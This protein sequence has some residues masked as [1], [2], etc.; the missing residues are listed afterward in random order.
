[1]EY[2]ESLGWR[3]PSDCTVRATA[4]ACAVS[5]EE[6]YEA[7]RRAGRIK[8]HGFAYPDFVFGVPGPELVGAKVV[9]VM[10]R[11]KFDRK[12][13]EHGR[14]V[15]KV[16][17][18]VFAVVDGV[19]NEAIARRLARSFRYAWKFELEENDY[20]NRSSQG[21]PVACGRDPQNQATAV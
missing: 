12:R 18:H 15:V 4:L 9:E 5:Y 8:G 2:R 11:S 3:E 14:W 16:P 7:L 10:P 6:A 1:M 17:H 20:V 13:L 21:L 19:A